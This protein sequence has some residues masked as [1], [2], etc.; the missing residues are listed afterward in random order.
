MYWDGCSIDWLHKNGIHINDVSYCMDLVTFF[1][2]SCSCRSAPLLSTFFIGAISCLL[3]LS[4]RTRP[5]GW[6]CLIAWTLFFPWPPR[7]VLFR[8]VH[9][10]FLQ[11]CSCRIES[12]AFGSWPRVTERC[13]FV[14]NCLFL[15]QN[16]TAY[17]CFSRRLPWRWARW[18]LCWYWRCWGLCCSCGRTYCFGLIRPSFIR[19]GTLITSFSR[20]EDFFVLF[21]RLRS[22]GCT[23]SLYR[24]FTRLQMTFRFFDLDRV[25]CEEPSS[26][27]V[28]PLTRARYLGSLSAGSAALPHSQSFF[29][30]LKYLR[31][32]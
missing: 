19:E 2:F 10:P 30:W 31:C 14:R 25:S 6:A 24:R 22:C 11:W 8:T 28:H 9:F 13:S 7:P 26:V 3:R 20:K 4:L 27:T 5:V 18:G 16:L 17:R 21:T 23:L 15:W 1:A 12:C 32:S 29:H